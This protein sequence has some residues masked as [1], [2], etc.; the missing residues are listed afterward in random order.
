MPC[1]VLIKYFDEMAE[2]CLSITEANV[3]LEEHVYF[4][5]ADKVVLRVTFN[6]GFD[7]FSLIRDRY[8]N[9]IYS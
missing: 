7:L 3:Y 4:K 8:E 5:G 2:V 6:A 1:D 9:L